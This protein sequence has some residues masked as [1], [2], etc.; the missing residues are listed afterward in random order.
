MT[1]SLILIEAYKLFKRSRAWIGPVLVFLLIIISFPLTLEVSSENPPEIYLSFVWIS[2][3]VVSMLGT[4]LIFS[5]D[6]EDGTLEQHA[7]NSQ[8]VEIV[9]YKILVHWILIGV[10][11]AFVAF[12]FVLSLD[13]SFQLG[14]MTLFCLIISNLIFI[15]FFSLG[16]SLSLKKGS[17]LGLLITIPLLIPLLILLGKMTTAAIL[18][19]DFISY[20]SLLA[21]VMILATCFIPFII[22]F[23]LKTHLE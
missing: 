7:I 16:N 18:G 9:F 15:N 5:D 17:I 21:G 3:L 22:S 1:R 20:L 10:P 4:E 12:L 19:L 13:F 11:I 2:A 6:F 23:I 8:L 14:L